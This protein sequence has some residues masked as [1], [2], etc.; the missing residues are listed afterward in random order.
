MRDFIS[1]SAYFGLALSVGAYILGS[2]LRRRF[3]YAVFN[4][5]LLA[6]VLIIS[7]L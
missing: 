6:V 2:I 5:L 4:P 3:N 1:S 7:L